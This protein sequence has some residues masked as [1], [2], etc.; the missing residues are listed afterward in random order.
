MISPPIHQDNIVPIA[1]FSAQVCRCDDS[2]AA[3]A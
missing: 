1:D 3:S 2:A